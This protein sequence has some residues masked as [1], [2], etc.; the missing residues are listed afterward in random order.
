MDNWM[1]VYERYSI[2]VEKVYA[3]VQPYLEYSLL[4]TGHW[5]ADVL[6]HHNYIY[7]KYDESLA[8]YKIKVSASEYNEENQC[9]LIGA[10]DDVN[11]LYAAADFQNQYL[12]YA[13]YTDSTGPKFYFNDLFHEPMKEYD[14]EFSPRIK[15][16][17][18]WTWGFVIYDYKKYIDNMVS[19]KLNTLILWNDYPPV[20][21]KEMIAYAHERG[22]QVYFGFAWGWDT[23]CAENKAV[24]RVMADT[25]RLS[26]EIIQVYETQYAALGCDGIYFQSFTELE[27]EKINGIP[28]AE[29][30]TKFVNDTAG[31]LF[32]HFGDIE[33]L[34]GLHA[35]SVK[36]KLDVIAQIDSRISILWEDCGAFPYHYIPKNTD[37]FDETVAF[38][39]KIRDM[40]RGGFGVVLKGLTCLDWNSFQHQQGEFLLGVQN[41]RFLSKK[42]EEKRKIW[43]YVQAYWLKN[44]K[45]AYDM[46]NVFDEN[47]MVTALAE[48]GAI[49]EKIPYSLAL[50]AE[51]LWDSR[52]PLD[53]IMCE[54]ALRDDISF[55]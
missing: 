8:G 17:G 53:E 14:R 32:E 24:A 35:G 50:Y 21:S 5:D 15:R 25:D 48:D 12:P 11:L 1:I 3:A 9:I 18:L 34:F 49:E 16:R 42:A 33:L 23:N 31:K 47:T 4:C 40:R 52:R 7:I 46:I 29:T 51:M 2:G 10:R 37:G 39:E 41:G 26:N 45:Y 30:V 20:N 6:A 38:T 19:L 44:A 54:T 43:K 28:V 27:E 55:A 13:R 36:N 22:I